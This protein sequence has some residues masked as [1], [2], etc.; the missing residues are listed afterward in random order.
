[1]MDVRAVLSAHHNHFILFYFRNT[2]SSTFGPTYQPLKSW[3]AL[4]NGQVTIQ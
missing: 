1:M 2:S 4:A 3:I